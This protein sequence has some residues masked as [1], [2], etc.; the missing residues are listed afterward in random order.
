MN[1][2]DLIENIYDKIKNLNFTV[3]NYKNDTVIQSLPVIAYVNKAKKLFEQNQLN[4]AEEIL[5]EALDIGE[6]AL[7]YKYLGKINERK[8]Q[9][10]PAVG[11]YD[12]SAYLNPNDKEIWLRL[13]MCELY[14][15][16]FKEA[17]F[18]FEKADKLSPMN[19]DIYTGWG[20]AYMRIKNML[21]LEINLLPHL[22]SASIITRLYCFLL[23]WR[24]VLA[25][26]PVQKIN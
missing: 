26:M 7:V 11:Y 19:T 9:F 22:K 3:D 13:G 24:F 10:K 6:D 17:I 20:M 23:L 12:K 5:L 8:G 1:L 25:N 4:E 18:S 2:F 14:S 21:R 16:M 15:D